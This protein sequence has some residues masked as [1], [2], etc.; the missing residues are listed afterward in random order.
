MQ[1]ETDLEIDEFAV[2]RRGLRDR[3]HKGV[4]PGKPAA[5]SGHEQAP[6]VQEAMGRLRRDRTSFVVA[7]R[8]STIREADTIVVMEAGRI[9]EQGDHDTLLAAGGAYARL[10]AAQFAGTAT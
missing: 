3:T 6:P 7:H 4:F 9:V 10:Y 2:F 8:L 5:I 1:V